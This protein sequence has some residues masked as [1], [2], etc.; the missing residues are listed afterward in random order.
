METLDAN[1]KVL[2]E[3][4]IFY[5]DVFIINSINYSSAKFFEFETITI[6]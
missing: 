5:I 4:L 6:G 3:T 1:L 2:Q